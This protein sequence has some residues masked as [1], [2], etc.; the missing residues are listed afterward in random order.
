M[1]IGGCK[2]LHPKWGWGISGTDPK[3]ASDYLIITGLLGDFAYGLMMLSMP[4]VLPISF[5]VLDALGIEY[6]NLVFYMF[7][8]SS[9]TLFSLL[10]IFIMTLNRYFAVVKPFSYKRYFSK[11]NIIAMSGC[12]TL[13]CTLFSTACAVLTFLAAHGGSDRSEI[14]LQAANLI[15]DFALFWPQIQFFLVIVDSSL[16]IFVYISIA[17]VYDISFAKLCCSTKRPQFDLKARY[18]A[19]TVLQ[20]ENFQDQIGLRL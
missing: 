15:N 10:M 6:Y 20:D 3:L 19:K 12:V 13:I 14:S 1:R 17:T 9:L 4:I 8:D 7:L 18:G 5:H 16:M 11:I 2:S